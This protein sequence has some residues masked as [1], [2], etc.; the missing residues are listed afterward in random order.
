ME[1]ILTTYIKSELLVL[2]VVLYFIGIALKQSK[3]KDNYIPLI[4]GVAGIAL[5]I[6]YVSITTGV[7]NAEAVLTGFIQGILCAAGSV[8]ANQMFKQLSNKE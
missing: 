7:L 1:E 2:V 6:A 8:Y 4:L 3:I 5:A